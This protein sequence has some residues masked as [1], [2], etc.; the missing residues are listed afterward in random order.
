[1]SEKIC[2]NKRKIWPKFMFLNIFKKI[3]KN[4]S[5]RIFEKLFLQLLFFLF[6]ETFSIKKFKFSSRGKTFKK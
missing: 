3:I 6:E 5:K 1:M 2:L 4:I